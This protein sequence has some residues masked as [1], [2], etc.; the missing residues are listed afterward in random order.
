MPIMPESDKTIT[1]FVDAVIESWKTERII[2]NKDGES[3][4]E[5]VI[6]E[7]RAYWQMHHIGTPFLG[8]F[9]LERENLENLFKNAYYHMTAH[10]AEVLQKQGLLLCQAYD[11]SIDA[12]S[13]ECMRDKNNT[14]QTLIQMLARAKIE[15]QYT[16]KEE[17][18]KSMMDGFLGRDAANHASS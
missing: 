16:L 14:N 17:A 1:D 15:R 2:E 11:Y 10:R 5:R 7:R 6:D 8:E 3:K 13:S 18:K 9:S 4:I 12:K